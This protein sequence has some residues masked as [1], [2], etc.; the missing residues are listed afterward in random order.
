MTH[1]ENRRRFSRIAFTAQTEICQGEKR[2]P[3]ELLDLSLKGLLVSPPPQAQIDPHTPCTIIVTLADE[4][5]ITM[6]ASLA[7]DD[8]Q[9]LGFSC[10]EIDVDS[11]SHLRRLVELNIGDPEASNR[12]L[13]ELIATRT[14]EAGARADDID[15]DYPNDDYPNDDYPTGDHPN[16]DH[17]DN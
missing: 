17:S 15:D 14:K 5:Q 16:E 13:F 8:A 11:I 7:R 3:C 1:T 12:E 9:H 6:Q 4:A 10:E 2:W